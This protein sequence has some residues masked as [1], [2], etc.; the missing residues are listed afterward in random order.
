MATKKLSPKTQ[1]TVLDAFD[2]VIE[3]ARQEFEAKKAEELAAWKKELARMKEEDLYQFNKEKRERE[4][5]LEEELKVRKKEVAD[6]EREVTAREEDV[7][8]KQEYIAELESKV[9]SI[10][11]LTANAESV[12]Y[13][14]GK[15]EVEKEYEAKIQL[16][17]AENKADKRVLESKIASLE[18]TVASQE[19]MIK[20]LREQLN[21][22]NSR[23]EAI[24]TSAVVAAG[25]SKV[26][27]QTATSGK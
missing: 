21:A 3:E 18:D 11:T 2:A 13:S 22:A 23:V 9:A 17:E 16:M 26:T 12:G 14:K 10:P 15:A 24:A 8:L 20:D 5:S 4:D 6:R 7:T 1:Q 27:V 25:N 19:A